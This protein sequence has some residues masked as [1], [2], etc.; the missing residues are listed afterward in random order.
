M[1]I[2]VITAGH[3]DT[4]PGAISPIGIT[5]QSIALDARDKLAEKMLARGHA[6]LLD[7]ETGQ[8]LPLP[9]AMA[10]ISRGA[11]AIELHCNSFSSSSAT[12]VETIS[13]P[14]DKALAQDLSKAIANA[15]GL[16]TRGDQGWIDQTKSARGR[17]GYVSA[18]GLIVELFFLSNPNDYAAWL[19]H[20][21]AALEAMADVLERHCGC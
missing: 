11:I 1:S 14:K 10:L 16:R 18:G 3:S 17:L 2:F 15:L 13:L 5:E 4:D 8:N 20:H 21:D 7:G 9:A 19:L 12:G 6:V